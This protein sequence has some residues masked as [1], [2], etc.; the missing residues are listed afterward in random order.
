MLFVVK[1]EDPEIVVG[2]LKHKSIG[3]ELMMIPVLDYI[4]MLRGAADTMLSPFGTF[5]MK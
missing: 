4:V 2:A 1:G 3:S 5:A